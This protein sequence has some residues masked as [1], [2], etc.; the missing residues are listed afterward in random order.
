MRSIR[1]IPFGEK[2]ALEEIRRRSSKASMVVNADLVRAGQREAR[3]EKLSK[4][5]LDNKRVRQRCDDRPG[6]EPR[7]EGSL[8]SEGIVTPRPIRRYRHDRTPVRSSVAPLTFTRVPSPL[9]LPHS[10]RR[11]LASS[12]T[13]VDHT[14]SPDTTVQR[15][16]TTTTDTG[17]D[18]RT[19]ESTDRVSPPIAVEAPASQAFDGYQAQPVDEAERLGDNLPL[20]RRERIRARF[21]EEHIRDTEAY[22]AEIQRELADAGAVVHRQEDERLKSVPRWQERGDISGSAGAHVPNANP[23]QQ[24]DETQRQTEEVLAGVLDRMSA[25]NGRK[26]EIASG[27]D[28]VAAPPS[29]M[30]SAQAATTR[31][32]TTKEPT[33][34]A[35]ACE[36]AEVSGDSIPRGRSW[37]EELDALNSLE[38][39]FFTASQAH[40][41]LSTVKYGLDEGAGIRT[42]LGVGRRAAQGD[43]GL[44]VNYSSTSSRGAHSATEASRAISG[45]SA[46]NQTQIHP[47]ERGK[48]GMKG[49]DMPAIPEPTQRTPQQVTEAV[50][51]H[52]PD[53]TARASSSLTNQMNAV[54]AQSRLLQQ[55]HDPASSWDGVPHLEEAP[56]DKSLSNVMGVKT[57]SR[58]RTALPATVATAKNRTAL[59]DGMSGL[60]MTEYLH[61]V[62]NSVPFVKTEMQLRNEQRRKRIAD[63]R[64]KEKDV[65][66]RRLTEY[67]GFEERRL[68]AEQLALVSRKSERGADDP[69]EPSRTRMQ[70]T[71]HGDSSDA[72]GRLI[73]KRRSGPGREGDDQAIPTSSAD[74]VDFHLSPTQINTPSTPAR[75]RARTWSR[76][77]ITANLSG[78]REAQQWADTQESREVLALRKLHISHALTEELT[79]SIRHPY[80]PT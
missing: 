5:A 16:R 22:L 25:T 41:L 74:P 61:G 21:E 31:S 65:P 46:L 17:I 50:G 54:P 66:A 10:I 55:L 71:A 58:S 67:Q 15:P 49:E 6:V 69:F 4:L 13:H 33:Q 73:T 40:Q 70:P 48:I 11:P 63:K 62:L 28:W 36:V 59:K 18:S 34:R 32:E 72:A 44:D 26:N 7:I 35:T 30:T 42:N 20:R 78:R 19:T 56:H 60:Q 77:S 75:G 12:D 51:S 68:R 29:V 27:S 38:D 80:N 2:D 1:T 14:E 47:A 24:A 23:Q 3:L 8:P 57:G 76:R 53:K 43:V 9:P 37:Q 45:V 52:H 79:L 64:K 39:Q